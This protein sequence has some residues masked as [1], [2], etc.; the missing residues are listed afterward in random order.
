MERTC[1]EC[2]SPATVL[3]LDAYGPGKD[4]ELCT[5]CFISDYRIDTVDIPTAVLGVPAYVMTFTEESTCA[6]CGSYICAPGAIHD[7]IVDHPDYNLT[8]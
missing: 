3:A 4:C 6:N 5:V 8:S 7:P 2:G 1:V